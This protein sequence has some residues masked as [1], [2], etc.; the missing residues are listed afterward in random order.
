MSRLAWITGDRQIATANADGSDARL[1]TTPF[2]RGFGS[3]NQLARSQLTWSWPT[4]SP[5][6]AWVAGFAVESSDERAGPVQVIAQSVD[7]AEEV[8]WFESAASLPIYMQWHPDGSAL[9]VL[10]QRGKE[11]NL[12]VVSKA[13]IGVARPVEAGV[14]LFFTWTPSG[15]RMLVHASDGASS[16]G[17]IVLRDPLGE[18]EDVLYDLRPGSFCAP[19][20]VGAEAIWCTPDDGG[21]LVYASNQEGGRGRPLVNRKGLLALVPAPKGARLL[22]VSSATK[23]EGSPYH[24]IDLVDLADGSLRSLTRMDCLAFFWSPTGDWLLVAQVASD[25]NCLRWWKVPIDGSPPIDVGTFWPTRDVVFYLHFFDQYTSSHPLVSADGQH[26][27]FAGYPA[28]GGQADLSRPPRVYLKDV[29]QPDAP[30]V[31]VDSGSF[32]VF[33][34]I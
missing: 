33:S 14:P 27:V 17:R 5:D 22:A 12:T 3:W 2:P 28:G 9:A 26:I 25:E 6:G 31:E 23:G 20:F 7:G 29:E 15:D 13:R 24:G 8:Q 34:S 30:A 21:S 11:L 18:A 10:S 32:A 4:W 16:Q 1:L 19:V